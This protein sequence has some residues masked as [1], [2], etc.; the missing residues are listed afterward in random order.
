MFDLKS[1]EW[2]PP[3][4][5]LTVVD[6]Y[7]T[8]PFIP[9]GYK[10]VG[11]EMPQKGKHYLGRDETV[12]DGETM[13]RDTGFDNTPRI[14]LEK[15][16]LRRWVVEED[17]AATNWEGNTIGA[18]PIYNSNDEQICYARIVRELNGRLCE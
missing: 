1:F 2:V 8:I 9:K 4:K 12:W 5:P 10:A 6:V 3:V 15:I 13:C 18:F 7:G 11:F 14:V 16:S 17:I